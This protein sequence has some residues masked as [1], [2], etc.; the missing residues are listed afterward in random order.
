MQRLYH[1]IVARMLNAA[2]KAVRVP[3]WVR[4]ALE[5]PK[6]SMQAAICVRARKQAAFLR[7]GSTIM[8]AEPFSCLSPQLASAASASYGAGT[9]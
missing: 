7:D 3:W 1:Q 4:A 5:L 9:K 8:N 2:P 6:S